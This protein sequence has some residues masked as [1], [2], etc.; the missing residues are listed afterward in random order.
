MKQLSLGT[1]GVEVSAICL[2]A[3]RFGTRTDEATS[4]AILDAYLE[5][6]GSFLDTANIYA[7]WEPG[8]KGGESEALLGRWFKAR[9]NRKACFLAT[10]MGS[11]LQPGGL[12]L[13][14]AQIETECEASLRRMG[15]ETIDLYYAHFDD[16]VTPYEETFAAFD[17]LIRAGK[18]R[19]LGASNHRAWRLEASRA[20]CQSRGFASYCC[21]QQRLSY[22]QPVVGATFGNQVAANEDLLDYARS[23]NVRVLAYSPLLGGTYGNR[24]DRPVSDPYNT[25]H[26]AQRMHTVT[27]MAARLGV[28][29]SQVVLAWML[30]GD[31]AVLPI[32]GVSTPGQLRENLGALQVRLSAADR[33][34]LA[35]G[36]HLPAPK[37]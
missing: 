34:E 16:P 22:L 26:N 5:A 35:K 3:M 33:D 19:F 25:P 27:T 28:T 9:G 37:A 24:P 21:V 13:R 7:V 18:V 17:R 12:G 36:G 14:A 20:F 6:G 11:K 32:V 2:G 30:H 10:K 23:R 31:P 1:T 4:F 8:G 15:V 29:P